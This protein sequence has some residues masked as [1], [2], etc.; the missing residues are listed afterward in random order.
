M[1]RGVVAAELRREFTLQLFVR[2]LRFGLAPLRGHLNRIAA[3][4]RCCRRSRGRRR[5]RRTRAR[6]CSRNL[7]VGSNARRIAFSRRHERK[8]RVRIARSNRPRRRR[9]VRR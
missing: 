2:G 3:A 4:Q 5:Q 1:D 7:S 6:F 8:R 9:R